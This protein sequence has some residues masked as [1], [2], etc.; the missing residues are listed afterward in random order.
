MGVCLSFLAEF[1]PLLLQFLIIF[2]QSH[3]SVPSLSSIVRRD[4]SCFASL[5]S[6]FL[7]NQDL[8][9]RRVGGLK[10]IYLAN[11]AEGGFGWCEMEVVVGLDGLKWV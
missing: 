4:T 8:Q 9:S 5:L 1:I 7:L 10:R 11:G 2:L 6:F 3:P